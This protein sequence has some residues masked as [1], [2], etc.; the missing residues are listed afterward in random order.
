MCDANRIIVLEG[1]QRLVGVG[2][3]G[4]LGCWCY[5]TGKSYGNVGESGLEWVCVRDSGRLGL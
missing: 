1:V 5:G 3:V 4:K 2:V